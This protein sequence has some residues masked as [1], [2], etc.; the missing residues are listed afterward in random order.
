MLTQ[1]QINLLNN[2][3]VLLQKNKALAQIEQLMLSCTPGLLALADNLPA[4]K[5]YLLKSPKLS[6]GEKYNNLPYRVLDFPRYYKKENAF[7]GR[8][9][10]LWAQPFSFQFYLAGKAFQN[11]QS[12]LLKN[13]ATE[14]ETDWLIGINTDPWNHN[15]SEDNYL[16]L[17]TSS[18]EDI[19]QLANRPFLKI[20]RTLPLEEWHL[21]PE[22]SC[23]AFC[24]F[25]SLLK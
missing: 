24:Q 7:A 1:E 3:E 17:A 6:R 15:L 8:L 16:S 14:K 20:A 21:L 2:V 23:K 12:A 5:P 10:Y 11:H 25:L 9:M 18:I 4:L 13:L 22:F 19:H